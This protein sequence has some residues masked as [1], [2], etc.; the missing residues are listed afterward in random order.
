MPTI[1]LPMPPNIFL[2]VAAATV[3]LVVIVILQSR[4]WAVKKRSDRT[5]LPHLDENVQFTVY[6]PDVVRPQQWYPM[7]AF[8]HLSE[9]APD[10]DDDLDPLEEVRRQAKQ[11]LGDNLDQYSGLTQDGRQA[12]PREGELTFVP[13]VP[14]IRFNPPR[15]SFRWQEAVHREEFRLRASSNLDGRTARGRLTV[16]LGAMLLA[17]VPLQIRV[18]S[19]CPAGPKTPSMKTAAARPYRRIFASYSHKDAPVVQQCAGFAAALGDQYLRDCVDLRAG[20]VWSER[21][22]DLIR[23]ADVFQLFWSTNSMHSSFVQQEWEYALT[24]NRPSFIRPTYWEEPLPEDPAAGLPP[25]AL[26][27]LHFQQLACGM[28]DQS[29]LQSTAS[30]LPP[31]GPMQK[32]RAPVLGRPSPSAPKQAGDKRRSYASSAALL[33]PV[34]IVL[35]IMDMV[36]EQS[37]KSGLESVRVA[38]QTYGSDHARRMPDIDEAGRPDAPN[39]VR[40]LTGRTQ[41]DGRLD[42]AGP[43]GPYLERFPANKFAKENNDGVSFGTSDPSP[44]DG[45]SGWYYNTETGRF[46]ANDPKHKNL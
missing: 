25:D 26:R 36:N 30:I 14:G 19:R 18:D 9:K 1:I 23:K 33:L 3:V 37:V 39:F 15:R 34:L 35:I 16:F 22:E 27:R 11:V 46:S 29:R 31:Q 13:E 5:R 4:A 41:P 42:P 7:L 38:I 8:A 21:L 24:L 43:C 2:L 6:R 12:V 45:T 20:E 40:R 10:A 28:V 17:D 44:G 32:D